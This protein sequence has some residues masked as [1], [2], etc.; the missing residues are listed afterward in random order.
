MNAVAGSR[1]ATFWAEGAEEIRKFVSEPYE[2]KVDIKF[3]TFRDKFSVFSLLYVLSIFGYMFAVLSIFAAANNVSV[4]YLFSSMM[5]NTFRGPILEEYYF[6]FSFA[7]A[8]YI[9][10]A[11]FLFPLW[12]FL[13]YAADPIISHLL[14]AIIALLVILLEINDGRLFYGFF[15]WGGLAFIVLAAPFYL[16]KILNTYRIDKDRQAHLLFVASVALL[17]WA[18]WLQ[19]GGNWQQMA[20]LDSPIV[21]P[22]VNWKIPFTDS[23]GFLFALLGFVHDPVAGSLSVAVQAHINEIVLFMG[24]GLLFLFAEIRL[25]KSAVGVQPRFAL[26]AFVL[27]WL[28]V[29]VEVALHWSGTPALPPELILFNRAFAVLAFGVYLFW[30]RVAKYGEPVRGAD[31]VFKAACDWAELEGWKIAAWLLGLLWLSTQLSHTWLNDF[32]EAIQYIICIV[33]LGVPLR[34]IIG[35]KHEFDTLLVPYRNALQLER[36]S[37]QPPPVVA[38]EKETRDALGDDDDDDKGR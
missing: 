3:N 27:F 11:I 38:T 17:G 29:F 22:L 5:D 24:A 32:P 23:I 33:L 12:K 18:L 35:F 20:V 34:K 8:A 21:L 31:G 19:N 25:H 14:I 4:T 36:E 16:A 15:G 9:T 30:R 28:A 6:A 37:Y 13:E 1:W 26:L 7:H 2:R 10:F